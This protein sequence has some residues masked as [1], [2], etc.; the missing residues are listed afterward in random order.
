MAFCS[1][2]LTVF[3]TF[4]LLLDPFGNDGRIA[5]AD[6]AASARDFEL[7]EKQEPSIFEGPPTYG[8]FILSREKRSTSSSV[9]L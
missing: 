8:P 7:Q 4:V 6:G 9:R 5:G 1:T 2:F 3:L